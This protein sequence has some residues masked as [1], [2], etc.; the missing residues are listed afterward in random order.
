LQSADC[1]GFVFRKTH[2]SRQGSGT[3]FKLFAVKVFR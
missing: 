1:K 3:G 2:L